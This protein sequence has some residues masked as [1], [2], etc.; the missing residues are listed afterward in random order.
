[1]L[2]GAG[3]ARAPRRRENPRAPGARPRERVLTR[4]ARPRS[5]DSRSSRSSAAGQRPRAPTPR[6][7]EYEPACAGAR[8]AP[9]G[10]PRRRRARAPAGQ[11]APRAC[12]CSGSAIAGEL[13]QPRAARNPRARFD[14]VW[15]I[16][17]RSTW[18]EQPGAE[19]ELEVEHLAGDGADRAWHGGDA[20]L[21]ERVGETVDAAVVMSRVEPARQLGREQLRWLT[22]RGLNQAVAMERRAAPTKG[23]TAGSAPLTVLAD[24][25]SD[26]RAALAPPRR[27]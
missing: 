10:R 22:R 14:A 9:G 13:D 6:T 25:S 2:H 4:R 15:A 3:R 26:R 12:A 24:W 21:L 8:M 17:Q 27:A 20:S 1:M 7:A 16:V 5:R 19:I 11:Q 23:S 18:C